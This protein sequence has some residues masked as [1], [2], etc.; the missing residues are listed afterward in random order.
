MI[1][2][3]YFAWGTVPCADHIIACSSGSFPGAL[4]SGLQSRDAVRLHPRLLGMRPEVY[5]AELTN[6]L[7]NRIK[8]GATPVLDIGAHVG[9]SHFGK[10]QP[11]RAVL[12]TLWLTRSAAQPRRYG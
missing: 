7:A 1:M 4:W 9:H 5:E 8:P 10:I 6:I 3:R 2:F 11:I 12:P